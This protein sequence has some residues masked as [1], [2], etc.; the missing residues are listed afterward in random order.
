MSK[1]LKYIRLK[2]GSRKE[3]YRDLF[4]IS[5][6]Q[7][8]CLYQRMATFSDDM[9][10]LC[11]KSHCPNE[12]NIILQNAVNRICTKCETW[13]IKINEDKSCNIIFINRF[14]S[15]KPIVINNKVVETKNDT[16]YLGLHLHKR[17]TWH[18]HI[19]TE[20]SD[21]NI[22]IRRMLPAYRQEIE[23]LGV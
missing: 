13:G 3:L 20:R 6:T 9:V 21:L 17:L 18:R 22:K 23:A 5:Y 8:I 4:C 7:L 2:L 15:S 16:R 19:Q 12:A 14:I 10:T 11:N 1:Y